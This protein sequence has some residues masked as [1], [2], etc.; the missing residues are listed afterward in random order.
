[1]GIA[2]NV[3]QTRIISQIVSGIG[4]LGLGVIWRAENGQTKG[5]TTA[6][7]VWSTAALGILI[8]LGLWFESLMA[9]LMIMFILVSKKNGKPK[10]NSI[11]S[12]LIPNL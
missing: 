4:F 10:S 8:G 5:L 12:N 6:S 1:M 11:L 2:E 9:L 7:A 3:D